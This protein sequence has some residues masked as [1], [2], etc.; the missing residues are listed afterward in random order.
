MMFA[1]ML[2]ALIVA[3]L[4]TMAAHLVL[5]DEAHRPTTIMMMGHSGMK[6]DNHT[7]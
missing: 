6:H 1:M 4:V 5:K 2:T 3:R 7:C